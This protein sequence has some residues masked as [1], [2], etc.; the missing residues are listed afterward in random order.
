M[1]IQSIAVDGQRECLILDG[2]GVVISDAQSVFDDALDLANRSGGVLFGL[3]EF[4]KKLIDKR[5]HILERSA[6]DWHDHR[7]ER[8][9]FDRVAHHFQTGSGGGNDVAEGHVLEVEHGAQI[10]QDDD[11]IVFRDLTQPDQLV[12]VRGVHRVLVD[13]L[14]VTGIEQV[15]RRQRDLDIRRQWNIRSQ[16]R[17]NRQTTQPGRGL[18]AQIKV[19]RR[20]INFAER[21]AGVSFDLFIR[22]AVKRHRNIS[23]Q[24]QTRTGPG[25]T[26]RGLQKAQLHANL[27]VGHIKGGRRCQRDVFHTQRKRTFAQDVAHVVHGFVYGAVQCHHM[28]ATIADDLIS[29]A[30]KFQRVT[31]H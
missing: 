24:M 2:K 9:V 22:I 31:Q 26:S 16:T 3:F 19:Q 18:T 8:L 30:A 20:R 13:N 29:L 28:G 4:A 10:G 5:E 11:D 23:P 12:H 15:H 1:N 6:Y 14:E 27:K 21:E 17:I 25:A 7:I